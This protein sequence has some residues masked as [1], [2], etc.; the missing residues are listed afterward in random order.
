[1]LKPSNQTFVTGSRS[2]SWD[3]R[4][5]AAD[6]RFSG[7]EPTLRG[8]RFLFAVENA[9]EALEALVFALDRQLDAGIIES[10]RLSSEMTRALDELGIGRF[11]VGRGELVV[12]FRRSDVRR[13]RVTV[14]TSGTTGRPKPVQHSWD[15]LNTLVRIKEPEPHFWFVPYQIGSYAWYQMMCAG[16]F[17]EGQDLWCGDGEDPIEDLGH[18]LRAGVTAISA[19]P[20][21]WRY[22]L[23]NLTEDAL[24]AACLQSITLGGE[25]V[26]QAILD[27]LKATFPHA[28][29]RH[30]YASSEAGASIVTRDGRA[31]FPVEVLKRDRRGVGV[32]I[33]G[34][35]LFIRSRFSS[36][37]AAGKADDWLDTGDLVEIRD[38]RVHF[39][40]REGSDMVNVGGLKAFPA[41]IEAALLRHP[42]VQWAHVY[43]RRAPLVGNLP[44][45]KVVL[46]G[47]EPT[48]SDAEAELKA[49]LR[50][51]LPEH[52]VPR[53]WQF[54]DAVPLSTTLK[55]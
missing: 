33:E 12:P 51:S 20:T 47:E 23:L 4:L 17:M 15:T 9:T 52:A 40:G 1:M 53:S 5:D 6:R 18:A 7:L 2:R 3:E 28:A 35:K 32:R 37:A 42:S 31:G 19:T 41:E 14:L 27:E 36:A 55:S 48:K 25:I 45:A 39:L 54:L 21:F 11:A 43:A 26:D 50:S 22:A 44:A 8:T 49:Y 29:I 34:G 30:I 24:S 13:G 38:N 46:R 16:L 10:V